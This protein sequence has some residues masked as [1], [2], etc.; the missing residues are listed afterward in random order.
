MKLSRLQFR[1]RGLL[2]IIA[3]VAVVLWAWVTYFSPA[4]RWHRMIRSDNESAA[5]WDAA[6]RAL[7]GQ[8]SGL[9][10]AEA[11]SAL[12]SALSDSSYRVR[13]TAA[14]TL[15]GLRG[16][17]ARLAVPSLVLALQ[18]A[19]TTVRL[20]SAGS[21][22]SI[23]CPDDDMRKIALPALIERLKDRSPEVRIAAGFALTLMDQG[24][25]AIP[26]MTAAVREG[27]D[28]HGLAVLSLAL[29][30]SS[31]DDAIAALKSALGSYYPKIRQASADAL[32]RLSAAKSEPKR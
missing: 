9:E 2:I 7:K 21:L 1:S 31:D 17:E 22:G 12:C 14:S 18:D 25:S 20:W 16:A 32:A 30:G 6:S 4:G 29:C 26:I 28:K 24:E 13:E 3:C 8:I 19:D 11:I 23:C 27:R 15:G 5:R 10:R